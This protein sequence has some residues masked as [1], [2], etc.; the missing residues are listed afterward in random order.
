MEIGYKLAGEA[1]GPSELI[2]QAVRAEEVGFDFVEMSDHFHPWLDVQGHSPFTWTVLGAIAARTERVGL[3]TGV[4]CPT[5]RYHPAI[6]AQ[7]A[8]T[9]A[10]VSQDRFTLGVG[11]RRCAPRTWPP[12]SRAV[13]TPTATSR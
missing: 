8:A 12:S 7:A 2:R 4:T 9:L 1:F 11:S 6:I 5:V 13:P 3:V 10:L